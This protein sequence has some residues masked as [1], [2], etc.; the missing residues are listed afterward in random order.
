MSPI[1]MIA[2]VVPPTRTN[3]TIPRLIGTV[4]IDGMGTAHPLAKVDPFILLDMVKIDKN[5][6]SP[7]GAHLHF[8]HSVAT[9]LLAGKVSSQDSIQLKDDILLGPGMCLVDAGSGLFHEEVTVIDDKRDPTQH[10][11]LFQLWMGVKDADRSKSALVQ[12][13]SRLSTVECVDA[14]S[15]EVVGCATY[16]LGD[17]TLIETLHPIM[18][19]HVQ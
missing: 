10:V 17:E 7:F 12:F 14:E 5:A 19:I 18:V 16:Y 9:I 15:G 4:D 13:E 3:P 6:M 11:K 1:L 8:G 2:R